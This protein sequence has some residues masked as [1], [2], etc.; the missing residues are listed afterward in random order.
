MKIGI[1]DFK[2]DQF[3]NDVISKLTGIEVE[4]LSIGERAIPLKS[5]Y[6]VIIYRFGF[7]D[8]YL[9]E[10]MKILSLRGTYV[11]NNPFTFTVT[12]KIVNLELCNSLGI[13][14]P[15]T[16][17][18]PRFDEEEGPEGIRE[19]EW[20][21][22]ERNMAFP[23]VLKPFD[24]YGWGDVYVV[25]SISE[26]KNLYDALKS[27]H[28]LLLQSRIEYKDYYRVFCINKKDVLFIKWNPK[29]GAMGEYIYSDLKPIEH[30]KDKLTQWTIELNSVLDLDFNA[31]EWSIDKNGNPFLIDAFNEVPDV[32][33]GSIPE[34][35]YNWIVDRFVACVKE[36]FNS[37]I[38][39][40]N[41]FSQPIFLRK[42]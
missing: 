10:I 16:V 23:C 9:T 26:L 17:I 7:Y 41:I 14:T 13:S 36:K 35:Y 28:I 21:N 33:K 22:I 40:R 20:E 2:D 32:P 34:P 38:R 24:G 5:E 27:K 15:K 12:N 18:L 37:N 42:S 1:F 11:I 3:I 25:N 39:N 4:F 6:R 19:P 31:V 29:P 30:I 8:P